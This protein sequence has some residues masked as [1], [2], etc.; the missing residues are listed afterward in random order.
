MSLYISSPTGS[1]RNEKNNANQKEAKDGPISDFH[2]RI[3]AK[4]NIYSDQSQLINQK[5]I[6]GDH[7]E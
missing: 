4:N 3:S 1:N 7:N 6:L 2:E 5:A